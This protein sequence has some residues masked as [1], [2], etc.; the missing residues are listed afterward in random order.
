MLGSG[1]SRFQVMAPLADPQILACI[2]GI[3]ANW[4]VLPF[5][6]RLLY[7]ETLLVDDDR[8]DPTIHI[9][10]IHDA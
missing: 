10:S 6:D 3:L 8:R 1:R 4:N 7:I 9:V 2:R 5:A